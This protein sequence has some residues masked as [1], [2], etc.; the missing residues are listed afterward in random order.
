MKFNLSESQPV[1]RLKP[2]SLSPFHSSRQQIKW[3]IHCSILVHKFPP[4]LSSSLQSQSY[5]LADNLSFAAALLYFY[6]AETPLKHRLA[7]T[8]PS[9]LQ[10]LEGCW[11]TLINSR[12]HRIKVTATLTIKGGKKK[13][14]SAPR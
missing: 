2:G 6:S 12:P 11:C 13:L 5:R 4:Q 8:I 3:K 1:L 10:A 14:R 7:E 9:A